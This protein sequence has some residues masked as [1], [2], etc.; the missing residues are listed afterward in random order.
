MNSRSW[1][2]TNHN[3]LMKNKDNPKNTRPRIEVDGSAIGSRALKPMESLVKKINTY[4][5]NISFE[6][7]WKPPSLALPFGRGCIL[8]FH[9]YVSWE[10]LKDTC[11]AKGQTRI[12]KFKINETLKRIGGAFLAVNTTFTSKN[13]GVPAKTPIYLFEK[14]LSADDSLI[15]RISILINLKKRFFLISLE[16]RPY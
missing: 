12:C 5:F 15:V 9:F 6:N 10:R 8:R 2:L 1:W 14:R 16:P 4:L 3:N 11:G 7:F 13:P